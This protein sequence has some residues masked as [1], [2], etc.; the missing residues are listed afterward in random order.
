MSALLLMVV[1]VCRGIVVWGEKTVVNAS[2]VWCRLGGLS[3]N[4]F[5][6]EVEQCSERICVILNSCLKTIKNPLSFSI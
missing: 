1:S 6:M 3:F 2:L 4:I 5:W